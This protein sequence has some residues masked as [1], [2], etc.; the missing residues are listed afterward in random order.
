LGEIALSPLTFLAN[1]LS[2]SAVF[3]PSTIGWWGECSTTMLL[4]LALDLKEDLAEIMMPMLNWF[5]LGC[6]N[7]KK[8]C[9]VNDEN[10][11]LFLCWPKEL[12]KTHLYKFN[13]EIIIKE[14]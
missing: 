14:H 3:E 7:K 2:P 12:L 5:R 13:F 4:P 10:P 11:T 9:V 6:F 8:H 1:F